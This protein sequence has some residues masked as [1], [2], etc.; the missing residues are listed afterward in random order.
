MERLYKFTFELNGAINGDD[1]GE[2]DYLGGKI[3]LESNKPNTTINLTIMANR[4]EEA[5]K[6]FS[7][8]KLKNHTRG[9]LKRVSLYV[10]RKYTLIV[11]KA[12]TINDKTIYED[13][14]YKPNMRKIDIHNWYEDEW[15]HPKDCQFFVVS[16]IDSNNEVVVMFE[17]RKG[18]KVADKYIIGG[19][20][21]F[22]SKF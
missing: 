6:L 14:I 4:Q 22:K 21:K 8:F 18:N 3:N 15:N 17:R 20:N 16:I 7:E 9:K 10:N 12:N 1:K 19:A 2:I 5:V 13:F 11:K